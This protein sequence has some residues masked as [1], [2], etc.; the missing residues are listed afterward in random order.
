MPRSSPTSD[1]QTFLAPLLHRSTSISPPGDHIVTR[2]SALDPAPSSPISAA[3]PAADAAATASAAASEASW[4]VLRHR[5]WG[6]PGWGGHAG[7]IASGPVTFGN[8]RCEPK[9][10]AA[11]ANTAAVASA[12]AS[13]TSWNSPTK[14]CRSPP[15]EPMLP[16][17]PSML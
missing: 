2:L 1:A 14:Q 4:R 15:S 6:A 9:E 13:F 16:C 5:P 12:V 17:A 7:G 3:A 10:A 11:T 8:L